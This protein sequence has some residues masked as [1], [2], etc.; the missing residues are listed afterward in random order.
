MQYGRSTTH[1][2]TQIDFKAIQKSKVEMFKRFMA[3]K[4]MAESK[5]NVV[6]K[7]I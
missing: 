4:D 3:A 7:P 5:G 2:K 6:V 1:T